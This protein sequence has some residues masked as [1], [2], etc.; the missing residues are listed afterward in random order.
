MKTYKQNIILPADCK[1]LAFASCCAPC[2]VQAIEE[3]AGLPIKLSVIFYNPNIYPDEEYQKRKLENQRICKDLNVDFIDLDYNPS[4]WQVAVQ[5][6]EN[7]PERGA[8][9]S[10]CFLMRLKQVA[11]YAVKHGFLYFSSSFG[12]SRYKD[13]SQVQNAGEIAGKIMGI[14]YLALNFREGGRQEHRSQLIID[15]KLYNQN[16]CGCIFSKKVLQTD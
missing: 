11:E 14:K 1:A 15:K 6:L 4:V 2:A 3:L 13:A 5:G 7:E 8:R 16:Y 9:C 10:V 12:I